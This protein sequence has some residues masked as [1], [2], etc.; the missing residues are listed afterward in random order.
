MPSEEH[1]R[2]V[3][4][5]SVR[6]KESFDL[7]SF[8]SDFERFTALYQLPPEV[9]L[10]E[11]EVGGVPCQRLTP[12]KRAGQKAAAGVVVY[13]HGGGYVSGSPVTHRELMAR[14]AWA[15]GVPVVGV[16]YR[17]APEHP[18]PA[19]YEDCSA[20]FRAAAKG[21]LGEGPVA[22]AGDSA[23]G[24][25]A[26]ALAR[27]L[28][29]KGEGL[30][31]GLLLFSPWVDLT[32]S[33]ESI[34][35]RARQDK[36][37]QP[38]LLERTASLYLDGADPKDPRVSPLFTSLEGLPPTLIQVGTAELLLDDALRLA[39][40]LESYGVTVELKVWEAMVHVWHLYA[41]LI[42]E[43]RQAIEEAAAFLRRLLG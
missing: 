29:Q 11:V 20:A 42:P 28:R 15:A 1:R 2:L 25:L 19:A 21:D 37:L 35:G 18:F 40:R 22:L 10:D 9:A 5:L 43:G 24:G 7:A 6:K 26:V 23:G 30:P 16:R 4:M 14:L 27:E 13:F 3:Q 34:T 33:G 36:I 17:R 39:R 12:G 32:L 8:R 41:G 31:A 38:L